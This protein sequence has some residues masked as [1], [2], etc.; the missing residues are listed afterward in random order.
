MYFSIDSFK[1]QPNHSYAKLDP[2]KV[3]DED[4]LKEGEGVLTEVEGDEKRSKQDFAL[5]KKSKPNEP[6]WESPWGKGRPG[7][8]IE[9]SAMIH[10][11]FMTN[12]IDIHSGGVDLKFPHHDNEIAQ[13]EA[14]YNTDS[15]V[16]YWLHI[17]HLNIK[18][19]KMSKSLKNFSTIKEY[20]S[21]YNHRELRFL[22][23]MNQW[24]TKMNFNPETS[25]EEARSKDKEFKNFFRTMKAIIKEFD[26]KTHD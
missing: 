15:W 14:F 19:Q 9:C 4:A 24:D 11:V 13:A 21:E 17:G 16:K 20:L 10:S 25:L 18:G 26:I 22:F 8:H 3:G 7:W 5:W 6:F 23:L 12:D 1:S 2:S